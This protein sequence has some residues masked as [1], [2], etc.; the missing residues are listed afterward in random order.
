MEKFISNFKGFDGRIGRQTFWLGAIALVVVS[1]IIS[2]LILPLLGLSLVPN[3]AGIVPPAGTDAD[4]AKAA[5]AMSKLIADATSKSGWISLIM[6]VIFAYPFAALGIKRR[7]DRDNSGRDVLVYYGLTAVLLLIQALGL[8]YTTTDLGNGVLIPTPT[9]PM[10]IA[11]FAL[12][13][14]GLYLLVVLGFLKG[15]SGANQYGADPLGGA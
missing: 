12:A 5:E 2:M 15:T 10:M 7:H 14:Y 13:I 3:L 11:N 4:P 9:M 6:F 8:A 1:I